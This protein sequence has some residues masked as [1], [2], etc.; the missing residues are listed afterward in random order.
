[1]AHAVQRLYPEVKVKTHI[2]T[3]VYIRIHTYVYI[4]TYVYACI[5]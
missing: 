1:M 4:R 5:S 2:H 3:Y